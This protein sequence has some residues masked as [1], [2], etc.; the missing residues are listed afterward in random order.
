MGL[1]NL[2]FRAKTS[3]KKYCAKFSSFITRSD[4]RFNLKDL[5]ILIATIS[6][7]I[8]NYFHILQIQQNIKEVKDVLH[9]TMEKIGNKLDGFGDKLGNKLERVGEGIDNKITNINNQLADVKTYTHLGL[10]KFEDFKR[11]AF[12]DPSVYSN[13][14]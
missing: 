7:I 1:I 10:S 2:L 11:Y 4:F 9:L 13:S 8:N 12:S 6:T 14:I 3:K 5:A